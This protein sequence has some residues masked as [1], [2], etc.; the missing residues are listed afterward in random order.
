PSLMLW[1]VSE[2]GYAP[3]SRCLGNSG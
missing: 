1:I 2:L 3:A